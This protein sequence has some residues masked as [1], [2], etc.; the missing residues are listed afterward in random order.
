VEA[1][2]NKFYIFKLWR[3]DIK[4]RGFY[5]KLLTNTSKGINLYLCSKNYGEE[6]KQSFCGD[7]KYED[8]SA[9]DFPP[10][11]IIN[12]KDYDYLV[13]DGLSPTA[14]GKL[15]FE[16]ILETYQW[17]LRSEDGVFWTVCS[18]G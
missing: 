7:Y 14:T 17:S 15:E 12:R 6:N 8:I 4:T 18:I 5:M 10:N 2:T 11:K 9:S 3:E 1:G 16:I 13:L